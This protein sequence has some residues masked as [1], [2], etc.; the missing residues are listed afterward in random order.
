[1]PPVIPFLLPGRR[2]FC[3]LD[4][5]DVLN[6]RGFVD[7]LIGG[8]FD[9]NG[10]A[11]TVA[12]VGGEENLGLGILEACGEGPG[13]KTG[14]DGNHHG[15]YLQTGQKGRDEFG[16][17][18]HVESDGVPL[19][20]PQTFEVV[21]TLADLLGQR[22]IGY[23]F[24]IPGITL[25]DKGRFG[26]QPWQVAV[27]A[28]EDDIGLTATKPLGPGKALGEVQDLFVGSIPLHVEVFEAG[29]PEPSDV[30]D[31]SLDECLV[32][33]DVMPLHEAVDVAFLNHFRRR[34]PDDVFHDVLY[35]QSTQ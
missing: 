24:E 11:S 18:G 9:R 26:C 17:H 5:D 3:V 14:K 23:F 10:F 2:G 30:F 35:R 20:D 1:M 6:R 7:G 25:P 28:V 8:L 12:A 16:D 29:L 33:G 4:D 34:A 15:P 19:L 31:G 27:Q 32:I 13:P 21:G 22:A